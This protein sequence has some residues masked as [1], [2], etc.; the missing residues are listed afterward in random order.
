TYPVDGNVYAQ[1]L[2]KAN[3]TL[4]DGSTHNVVFVATEH[5]SVY[6]LNGDGPS[7]GAKNDGVLWQRSFI[8]PANGITTVPNSDVGSGDIQPQ[9]GTTGTPVIN[10]A[11]HTL[12]VI[13]AT[14]ENRSGVIHYVQRLY[15]LDITTGQDV[16][17][18]YVIGDTTNGNTNKSVISVSG[19]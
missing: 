15:A 7:G 10:A 3:L 18:P 19:T 12:Y 6:A 8:D 17:A 5:D 9:I 13:A 4:A 14:R 16:V 2:Y 11:T 1:P